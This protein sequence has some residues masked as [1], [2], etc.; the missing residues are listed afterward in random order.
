[1]KKEAK[2]RYDRH[3][4]VGIRELI[5]RQPVVVLPVGSTEDHGYHLPL[6]TDNYLCWRLCEEAISRIPGEALLLPQIPYGFE[7]H[8]M[9]FPGTISIEASTLLNFVVDVAKSVAHHGFKRILIVNGHG[10][11]MPILDLAARKTVLDT[12]AMCAVLMWTSL[13]TDVAR[14]LRESVQGGMAHGGELETSV[15]LYLDEAKVRKDKIRKDISFP[16]SKYVWYELVETPPLHFMDWWSRISDTGTI[17]DPT[18][19]SVTKGKKMFEAG[20]ERFIEVLRDFR[21]I[22]RRP[23]KDHHQVE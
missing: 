21:K 5:N 17:G 13:I 23:R 10:S 9:E 11:N 1:M 15:Y 14:N 16:R 2:Y 18:V 8:H 12:D 3:T 22:E 7:D 4:W 20:V 6:D 19:A